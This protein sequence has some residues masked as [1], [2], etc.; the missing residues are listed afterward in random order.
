MDWTQ[1]R[2][3]ILRSQWLAGLSASQIAK[4]LGGV[5]KGAVLRAVIDLGLA[6]KQRTHLRP[7]TAADRGEE[8]GT[9]AFI[10]RVQEMECRIALASTT[11]LDGLKSLLD[12][13]I[14]DGVLAVQIPRD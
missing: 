1:E 13:W 4:N 9:I 8:E 7:L 2:L 14:V 5:T 12:R 11:S 6:N 10:K 3:D